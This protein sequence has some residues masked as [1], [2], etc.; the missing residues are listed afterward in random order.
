MASVDFPAGAFDAIV[1]F[2]SIIHLPVGDQPALFRRIA[3]W[4]KPGGA[5][6]ATLGSAAWTGTERDWLGV[7]GALM[8]WSHADAPTCRR[9][10]EEAGFEILSDEFVRGGRD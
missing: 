4:L 6:M 3:S 9:W 10:L 7:K 1:A 8:Y 5:F 2:Y